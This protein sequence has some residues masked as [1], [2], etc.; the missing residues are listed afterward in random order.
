[1]SSGTSDI[2]EAPSDYTF[3]VLDNVTTVDGNWVVGHSGQ[4]QKNASDSIY[5]T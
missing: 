5:L 2:V 1:M 3:Q 4:M